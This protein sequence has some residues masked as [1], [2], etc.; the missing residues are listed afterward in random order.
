MNEQEIK[1]VAGLLG[2]YH[3]I[4]NAPNE[5]NNIIIEGKTISI[6]VDGVVKYKRE[7]NVDTIKE[8]LEKM[9]YNRNIFKNSDSIYN[10]FEADRKENRC[11]S[12]QLFCG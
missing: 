8:E 7:L 9:P 5:L 10:P 2:T 6:I 11:S 12:G 4:A 1:Y 3:K